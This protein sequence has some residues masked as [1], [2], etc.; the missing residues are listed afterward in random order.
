MKIAFVGT[1]S[2]GK[3]TLLN[4][5]KKIYPGFNFVSE[6]ARHCPF[7]LN[8]K[9][10][11]ESQDWI[12]R[13]QIQGELEKPIHDVTICDRSVY[14]QLAYIVYAVDYGTISS[15]DGERLERFISN[16]GL[17]YDYLFY[18]PIEFDVEDDGFRSIDELY[19][20]TIDDHVQ[21]ILDKYVGTHRRMQLNGTVEERL[22]VVKNKLFELTSGE[23]ECEP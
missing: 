8:E 14:D 21:Y 17:T 4:E 16:W 1:H 9:T 10:T 12:L 19:R 13:K 3:T 18:I 22:G 15:E 6:V 2:V 11:L 5:L 20:K 7:S 23:K